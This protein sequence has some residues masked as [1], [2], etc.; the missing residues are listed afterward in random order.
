MAFVACAVVRYRL[1]LYPSLIFMCYIVVRI[2]Q[3][4]DLEMSWTGEI[5]AAMVPVGTIFGLVAMH[6]GR[7]ATGDWTIWFWMGEATVIGG[8]TF[9]SI[10]ALPATKLVMLLTIIFSTVV[11][12]WFRGKFWNY[13][14]VF[15]MEA[16]LALFVAL[17]FPIFEFILES[18]L[19][20][21]LK[22][23]GEKVRAHHALLEKHYESKLTETRES[24]RK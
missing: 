17:A 19:N 2:I 11:S 22:K 18:I 9:H 15:V 13:A 5:M 24:N 3:I 8:F 7:T 10:T 23:V 20:E 16:L 1:L 21:K 6:Y 14:I 4:R 12:L